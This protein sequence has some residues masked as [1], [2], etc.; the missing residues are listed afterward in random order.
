MSNSISRRLP[1]VFAAIVAL[2]TASAW[3]ANPTNWTT[4]L[5]E[6]GN[7]TPSASWTSTTPV[8]LGYPTYQY[9]YTIT[10][11]DAH[12]SIGWLNIMGQLDPNDLTGNGSI[13][14][15]PA[16]LSNLA[17]NETF[18]D[19][20]ITGN[21]SMSVDSNGFG[22]LDLT[23]FSFSGSLADGARAKADIVITGVVPEPTSFG[24]LALLGGLIL[25]RRRR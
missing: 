7:T 11:A 13:G 14:A 19:T 1:G 15:L 4:D 12:T 3:A 21:I 24:L 10:Q 25:P 8:D 5:L 20:T 9:S 18:G 6:V 2:S 16:S 23:G 17:V 22:H